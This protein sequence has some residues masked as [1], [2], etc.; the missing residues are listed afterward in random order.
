MTTISERLTDWSRTQA[1]STRPTHSA[2]TWHR[3]LLLLIVLM[4]V[5]ILV[6]L[7]G[8]VV[9]DRTLLGAP[10]WAKPFKFSVS[11]L[12]YA[13]ALTWMLSLLTRGRRVGWWLGTVITVAFVAEMAVIVGQ[14]ARGTMSHFNATTSVD[15]ALYTLMGNAIAVLWIATLLVAILLLRTA[16]PDPATRWAIR[17]GIVIALLGMSVGFL[18]V[19][20]SP[21]QIAGMDMSTR[22]PVGAHSVG[23]AD[24]GPGLPLVNWSTTGGDLRV[25]H[26]IGMHGL[27]A[28]HLFAAGLAILGVGRVDDRARLRLVLLAAG[29]YAGLTVLTTV[30]ALRGEPLLG[31]SWPVAAAAAALLVMLVG[32]SLIILR[33]ARPAPTLV[34]ADQ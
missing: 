8:L 29:G 5:T 14:A 3:P 34:G 1:G 4:A 28:L 30:Q 7:A 18:M 25:G 33:T 32:G 2:L 10:L 16:I 6:S 23:T 20:A 24:G 13:L 12:L 26:F 21:E 11:I 9:D 15:G 19:A 27:Q 31:P 22:T 17:L